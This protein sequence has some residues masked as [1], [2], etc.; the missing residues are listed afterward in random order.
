V[1][2]QL[3]LEL[4]KRSLHPTSLKWLGWCPR[5]SFVCI[6][7]I[8]LVRFRSSTVSIDSALVDDLGYDRFARAVKA[9]RRLARTSFHAEK[10][11]STQHR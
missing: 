10:I 3:K 7:L 9:Q 6:Y 11:T 4:L 5:Y 8:Y 1:K 2:T